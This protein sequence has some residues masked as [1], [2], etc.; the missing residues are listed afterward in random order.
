[1]PA[2][3]GGVEPP[4]VAALYERRTAV[5]DRR[6]KAMPSAKPRSTPS[7]LVNRRGGISVGFTHG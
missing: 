6:Y 2:D 3:P 1:M 4:L 5:I 7:G